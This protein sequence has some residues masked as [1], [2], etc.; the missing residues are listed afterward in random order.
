M[1]KNSN[2]ATAN[3]STLNYIPGTENLY[4]AFGLTK[5]EFRTILKRT[6]E[7]LKANSDNRGFQTDKALV[8]IWNEFSA[9]PA[10]LIVAIYCVQPEEKHLA[11]EEAGILDQPLSDTI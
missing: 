6:E 2:A 3:T 4:E 1:N 7:I 8:D 9:K 11:M 10:H 5:E